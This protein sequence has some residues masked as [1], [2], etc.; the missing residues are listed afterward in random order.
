MKEWRKFIVAGDPFQ[1]EPTVVL[2]VWK[3]E[4]IYTVVKL[5]SFAN[6]ILHRYDVK[7]LTM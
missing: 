2:N 5:D 1:I 4:N 6:T 3:G 7:H